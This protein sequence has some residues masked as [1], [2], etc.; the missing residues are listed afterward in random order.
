[1]TP[2]VAVVSDP[3]SPKPFETEVNHLIDFG[4]F[5]CHTDFVVKAKMEGENVDKNIFIIEVTRSRDRD[6]E[7]DRV[8][9]M[10]QDENIRGIL[11][12]HVQESP[13]FDIAS[14]PVEVSL[15]THFLTRLDR[16]NPS[17]DVFSTTN[18]TTVFPRW[19]GKLTCDLQ[20]QTRKLQKSAPWVRLWLMDCFL[21]EIPTSVFI[22]GN[23]GP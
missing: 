22:P 23:S 17:A 4:N 3:G 19:C 11:L 9:E 8:A 2:W 12:A 10:W 7:Q 18:P 20:F 16:G 21:P 14:M 15:Q 13:E 5:I 1:M 6:Q